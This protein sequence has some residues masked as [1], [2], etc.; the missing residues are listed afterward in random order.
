MKKLLLLLGLSSS[1]IASS[2]LPIDPKNDP[3]F[4]PLILKLEIERLQARMNFDK[5]YGPYKLGLSPLAHPSE[6]FIDKTSTHGFSDWCDQHL[7]DPY[8]DVKKRANNIR[9]QLQKMPSWFDQQE[10]EQFING[11]TKNTNHS[12][13]LLEDYKNFIIQ[14]HTPEE[15]NI[16]IQ[17]LQETLSLNNKLIAQKTVAIDRNF[18]D[19]VCRLTSND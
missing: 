15:T 3:S 9:S 18:W 10:V 14:P 1:I 16:K 2:T 8:K 17:N 5:V 12:I 4:N 6:Y 7:I 11:I 19:Q 13:E